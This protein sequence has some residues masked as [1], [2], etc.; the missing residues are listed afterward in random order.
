[1]RKLRAAAARGQVTAFYNGKPWRGSYRSIP[2][3]SHAV[4][5]VEIGKPIVKPKLN[6]NWYGNAG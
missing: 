1:L 6:V 4:I 5:T 2:L 3:R